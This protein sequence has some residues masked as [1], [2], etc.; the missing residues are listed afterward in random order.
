MRCERSLR[1]PF[2]CTRVGNVD[3]LEKRV[4]V[5]KQ[6]TDYQI[7]ILERPRGLCVGPGK[8]VSVMATQ[9]FCL[10]NTRFPPLGRCQKWSRSGNFCVQALEFA[11]TKRSKST[12]IEKSVKNTT[13]H[14]KSLRILTKSCKKVAVT[15]KL[16][17]YPSRMIILGPLF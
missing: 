5:T 8:Q 3:I 4:T 9:L 16:E 15:N 14:Q 1:E 11:A 10:E 2:L 13:N 7:D 6:E 17:G 12:K